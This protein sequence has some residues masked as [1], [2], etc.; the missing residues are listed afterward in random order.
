MIRFV[1]VSG[2]ALFCFGALDLIQAGEAIAVGRAIARNV[3]G[4]LTIQRAVEIARRQNPEILK[5]LQEIERTRGQV[6]EVRAQALPHV[7]LTGTY[8]QQDR[9]LV[10]SGGASNAA[11]QNSTSQLNDALRD[12][13]QQNNNGQ[14]TGQNGS[15]T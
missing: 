15:G 11:G 13:L 3:S 4:D 7:T 10:E 12:V 9:R 14:G 2:A 1:A 6:I 5:A 8:D